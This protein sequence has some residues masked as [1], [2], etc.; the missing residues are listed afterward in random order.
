MGIF[1]KYAVL[2]CTGASL[3]T[4]FA[5]PAWADQAA[6]QAASPADETDGVS[7]IVVRAQRF[8]QSLQKVP[9]AVTVVTGAD[10]ETR[11][12]HDLTQITS[13]VPSL[14]LGTDNTFTLR[15][16]GSTIFSTNVDASVGVMVD[17]VSLGVPLLMAHAA[18]NDLQ[19]IEVLT[20]PQG[21]L[22]G[23]N[24]SAGLINITTARPKLGEFSGSASLEYNNRDK[25]PGGH[26]GLIGSL[27][28]NVP[29][30]SNSALRFSVLESFQN[31]IAKAIVNK[32]PNA[33][34]NQLRFQPKMKFLWEP[35]DR[36]SFY[37][38]A[39][40]SRER[41]IG[42]IW[43]GTF[44]S[45]GAGGGDQAFL[46]AENIVPSPSN[47]LFGVS[48]ADFRSIDTGG[49]S[50]KISYK[51]SPT[52][53]ISDIV[54]WRA[55]NSK[56]N[57]DS[58][59]TS[60]SVLDI[61]GGFGHFNQYSN[62]LR[63]A[64]NTPSLDGQIGLYTYAS[65]L[66][67]SQVLDGSGGT[68]FPH[69]LYGN[70]DHYL[71]NRSLAVYGQFNYR[72]TPSLQLIAGGRLTDDHIHARVI[73][74]NYPGICPFAPGGSP[75]GT[76]VLIGGIPNQDYNVAADNTNFSYK[77]G[78][79]YDIKPDIS[80]YIS[81]GT[82]YKSPAFATNLAYVGQDPYILPE[83]VTDLEVGL[84]MFLFD[85]KLRFNV[86]GFIA[87][88][89]NLQTQSFTPTG[90][91][92]QGN[93]EGTRT[94]G[95]EVNATAR[96]AKALTVNFNAA[97]LDSHYTN[98]STNACYT[99]QSSATCPNGIF[100]QGAGITTPSSARFHSTLQGLYEVELGGASA[101]VFESNW[102]HRSSI[103]YQTNAAPFSAVG[104]VNV[105]GASLTY[106]SG[107]AFDI[108]IF[109]KNCTN[110]LV[111]TTIGGEPGDAG[112]GI[113]S[114]LQRWNYNSVRTIG[115]SVNLRF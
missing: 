48:G 71:S 6:P 106:K 34:L 68:P 74:G 2:M 47:L 82:G 60:A 1:S 30:G 94:A 108:A 58:D 14:E 51:I 52:L 29:L 13:Q 73:A 31:P 97:I 22:F 19:Q 9:V 46:A 100:F 98:Y 35:D 26:L 93:A 76:C 112:F 8:D 79:Q 75:N 67:E 111:P 50:A 72:I 25:A 66:D 78:A 55:Y 105:F 3:A 77:I 104:S 92:I 7:D 95:V 41:G 28:L 65:T 57:L 4:T 36:L 39:D 23:R 43:D 63:L 56:Y 18:F 113:V 115:A 70:S 81:Y 69:F 24:T 85:H 45:A 90:V 101:L 91:P 49:V 107:K 11:K 40:Y 103:N 42:G 44:R 109:C 114:V 53:T 20:G 16:V 64:I 102:F 83:T 27:M 99:G 62:E 84:K 110:R 96:P 38:I 86:A 37:L 54:A 61:N 15:G 88:F 59:F 32:S 17:D 10:L 87:N 89:T 80:A 33:Q 5:S 12:L 21:L